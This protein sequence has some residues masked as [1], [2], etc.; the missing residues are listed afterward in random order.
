MA[1]FYPASLGN[2]SDAKV[3]LLKG[4]TGGGFEVL[5]RLRHHIPMPGAGALLL[6]VFQRQHLETLEKVYQFGPVTIK[7]RMPLVAFTIVLDI[8]V[9]RY[10]PPFTET[11]LLE[12]IWPCSV[13]WD[14]AP[15]PPCIWPPT[16]RRWWPSKR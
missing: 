5:P 3:A 6:M 9:G 16:A 1:I 2:A 4:Y 14:L 13:K 10:L 12:S 7:M 8:G 11:T 15:V